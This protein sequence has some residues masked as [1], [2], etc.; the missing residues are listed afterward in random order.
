MG[1]GRREAGKKRIIH[2]VCTQFLRA[3]TLRRCQDMNCDAPADHNIDAVY[4]N[5]S[6]A[7]RGAQIFLGLGDISL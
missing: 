6:N 2:T 7:A 5:A 1:S 4:G 3:E